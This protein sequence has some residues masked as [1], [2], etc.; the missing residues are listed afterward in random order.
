MRPPQARHLDVQPS[1]LP[2]PPPSTMTSGI[3]QVDHLRQRA[4]VARRGAR[5]AGLR[6]GI[7]RTRRARWR[8]RRRRARRSARGRPPA[9]RRTETALPG[10]ASAPAASASSDALARSSGL[11]VHSPATP[12]Q[13][14]APA[15]APRCRRP[16]PVPRMAATPLSVRLGAVGRLRQRQAQL[17][18]FSS[19]T[20]RPSSACQVPRSG[21][22]LS[23]RIGVAH[24]TRR[25]RRRS[26]SACHARAAGQWRLLAPRFIATRAAMARSVAPCAVATRSRSKKPPCASSAAILDLVVRPGRCPGGIGGNVIWPRGWRTTAA[27]RARHRRHH[28]S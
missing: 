6:C 16:T 26:A 21:W 10:R 14:S 13:P 7:A 9:R 4:P 17:A 19:R 11:A 15:H 24:R 18:S 5:Q 22:P 2:R 20:G 8:R 25:R 27:R 23:G 28:P 1:T 12:L 3:D